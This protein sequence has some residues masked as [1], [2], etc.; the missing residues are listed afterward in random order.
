[1]TLNETT[2]FDTGDRV[3]TLRISHA[4]MNLVMNILENQTDTFVMTA[5]RAS[6]KLSA[7]LC[8]LTMIAEAFEAI[9]AKQKKQDE[10]D[11]WFEGN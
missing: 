6:P 4:E 5:M 11:N 7:K 8:L 3:Y 2:D 9:E 10:G 1:M